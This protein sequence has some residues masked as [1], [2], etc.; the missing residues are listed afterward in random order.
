[1]LYS[2]ITIRKDKQMAVSVKQVLMMVSGETT[3]P[4]EL[5]LE[6]EDFMEYLQT[7]DAEYSDLVEWVNE[8]Y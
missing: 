6:N 4:V 3:V 5:L 2:G 1:V 7:G 8:N